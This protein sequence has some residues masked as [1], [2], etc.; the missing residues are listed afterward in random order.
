VHGKV[1]GETITPAELNN[2]FVL[3]A[4][5]GSETTRNAT[6]HFVRLLAQHPEQYAR[7]RADLDALLP[8]AIEEALRFSPPVM[9][10]RRT[11]TADTVI[12][13]TQSA[14]DRSTS[15]LRERDE[16][17]FA[18]PD[19]FDIRRSPNHHI[20][21]GIGEHYCLGAN[22][23]RMQLRCILRE[24][25]TRLPDIHLVGA[26]KRQRS[27]LIQGI[28]EMRVEFTPES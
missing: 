6:S 5:A 16:D 22:F 26:P 25:L 17:V 14:G 2:F 24:L 27:N 3:L 11:A 10:F 7:L 12:R 9:Y 13:G 1:D 19:R 18:E 21:F 23:A 15:P 8:G 28:R 20:A 4:V